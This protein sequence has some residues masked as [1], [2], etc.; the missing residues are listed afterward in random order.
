M[1]T[2]EAQDIRPGMVLGDG[3]V[4]ESVYMAIGSIP[5]SH[6]AKG[7]AYG[8]IPGTAYLGPVGH[9]LTVRSK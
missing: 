6:F 7:K 2:V 4:V 9:K 3:F 5:R 8:V 1:A